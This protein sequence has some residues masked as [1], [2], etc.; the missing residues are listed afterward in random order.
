[1]PE[2]ASVPDKFIYEP[3]KMSVAQQE[4][5]GCMLGRDYPA[6]IVDHAQARERVLA[7]YKNNL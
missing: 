5:F 7:A 4:Q 2:L 1:V 3:W 6:P